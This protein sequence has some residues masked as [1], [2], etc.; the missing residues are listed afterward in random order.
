MRKIPKKYNPL[1]YEGYQE[2]L[3][4][5]TPITHIADILNERWG[6]DFPESSMRGRYEKEKLSAY[7]GDLDEAEYQERLFY[8]ARQELR[9]K[10]QR[11]ILNKQRGMVDAKAREFAEADM[12][13]QAIVAMYGEVQGDE[14]LVKSVAPTERE[15]IIIYGFGDVHWGYM[16]DQEVAGEQV[17]YNTEVARQRLSGIFAYIEADIKKHGYKEVYIADLADQI[18]GSSLRISQLLQITTDMTTQAVEYGQY[19][20]GLIQK[21]SKAVEAKLNIVV[22]SED[23]HSQLRSFNTQRD[24]LPGNMALVI[25]NDIKHFFDKMHEEGLYKNVNIMIGPEVV[26]SIDGF[27]LLMAHGHQY[28]R[29]DDIVLKAQQR[30]GMPIHL[31]L[32]GHFHQFSVKYRNVDFGGQQAL[33]FLPSVVGDT[34]FSK[35]LFLSC[36]PGF[37]KILVDAKAKISNAKFIRLD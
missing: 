32:A 1:I 21:L 15:D 24:A 10:E 37:S 16:V 27:N 6:T 33:V 22:V 28:G 20:I 29:K 8:I 18:E 17:V 36:Y 19:V 2:L 13:K 23:N 31:Y 30:H 26:L 3:D 25:A 7:N 4:R 34:D 35:K 14:P 5:G 11:K 9:L 12:V